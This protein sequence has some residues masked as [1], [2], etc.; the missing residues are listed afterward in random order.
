MSPF[1]SPR[2]LLQI[3]SFIHLPIFIMSIDMEKTDVPAP[4]S[5]FAP[6]ASTLKERIKARII[7]W[8]HDID[9]HLRDFFHVSGG[10]YYYQVAKQ[11]SQL[12]LPPIY[13][14]LPFVSFLSP[15]LKSTVAHG[16]HKA[17]ANT[18]QRSNATARKRSSVRRTPEAN[19]SSS[20]ASPTQS[21]APTTLLHASPPSHQSQQSQS[22]PSPL[23]KPN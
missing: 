18:S 11:E 22:P 1:S 16:H 9:A 6:P 19:T 8:G 12:L 13:P 15:I 14:D 4:T 20:T 5:P 7:S 17:P 3:K 23:C 2:L 10:P 21:P